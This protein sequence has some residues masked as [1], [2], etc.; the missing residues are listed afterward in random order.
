MNAMTALI[1]FTGWAFLL[2]LIVFGYRGVRLLGGTPINAWPRG[3]KPT[4]DAGFI[5]R[6]EDAH[7]NT[8]E[9]LPIFAVLVLAAQALGKTAVT[10]PIAMY[11]LYARVGQSTIHAIGTNQLLVLIRATLW[12]IQLIVFGLMFKGLLA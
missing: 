12:L 9:N 4:D 10:D 3:N 2:I 7:A 1:F 11:A 6:I 8:L 5:K